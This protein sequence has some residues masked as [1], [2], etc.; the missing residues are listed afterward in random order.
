MLPDILGSW[1]LCSLF[2][3]SL[4]R[5]TALGREV[6]DDWRQRGPYGP[7]TVV[8]LGCRLVGLK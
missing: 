2:V 7:L 5:H 4:G 6:G 3:P 8:N 1:E